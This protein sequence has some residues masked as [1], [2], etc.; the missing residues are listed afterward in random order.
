MKKGVL[1]PAGGEWTLREF[2]LHNN[3]FFVATNPEQESRVIGRTAQ[4]ELFVRLMTD[5]EKAAVR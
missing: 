2:S 5:K 1:L 4:G 3:S